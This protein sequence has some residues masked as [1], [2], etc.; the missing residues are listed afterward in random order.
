VALPAFA[1]VQSAVALLG[2]GQQLSAVFCLLGPQQQT[3]SSGMRREN[4]TDGHT[5][6]MRAV[7]KKPQSKDTDTSSRK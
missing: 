1:A 3:C 6:I 2:A 4:G 5:H 7:P